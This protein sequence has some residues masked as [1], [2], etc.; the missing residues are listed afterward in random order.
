MKVVCIQRLNAH[1]YKQQL[2][3]FLFSY[4]TQFSR[5]SICNLAHIKM[6]T[7]F[8]T[9]MS[10]FSSRCLHSFLEVVQSY[11]HG[12]N[13]NFNFHKTPQQKVKD[14]QIW[15][16]RRPGSKPSSAEPSLIKLSIQGCC[17]LILDV[18]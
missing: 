6:I 14:G 9:S 4:P 12:C 3:K 1:H 15:R 7:D 5:C 11:R 17:H 10:S 18:W 16:S 2:K 13:V 8:M